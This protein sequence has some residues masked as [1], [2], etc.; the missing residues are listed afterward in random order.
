MQAHRSEAL[1]RSSRVPVAVPLLVTSL[2]PTNDF[3]EVCETLVVS[4]HGCALRSPMKVQAGIPVHFHTK[5]GR[6]MTAQIIDCEPIG[7]NAQAWRLGAQLEQPNNF[8][9]LNPCPEDW[10]RA[11]NPAKPAAK[12]AASGVSASLP[13]N[14]PIPSANVNPAFSPDQLG[15]MVSPLLLPLRQEITAI[16]EKLLQRESNRSRFEVSLSHIPPELEK[17]LWTRLRQDLGQRALEITREESERV[18]AAAHAAIEQKIAAAQ[19]E[20]QQ[21]AS[22]QLKGVEQRLHAL[23]EGLAENV[24]QH[25][26][27]AVQ[28]FQRTVGQAETRLVQES[29]RLA[30]A[31]HQRLQEEHRAQR[32]EMQQLQETVTAEWS[33]V[34][35]QLADV[36]DRLAKLDDSAKRLEADFDG[37]ISAMA[38]DTVAA[39]KAQFESAAAGVL[40]Q[41]NTR[42]A[43][44][45]GVQLEDACGR[46]KQVE[47]EIQVAMS[48]ALQSRAADSERYFEQA[49]NDLARQCIGDWRSAL[50]RQL[51]SFAAVLGEQLRAPSDSPS[52]E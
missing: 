11:Q 40:T 50:A 16:H 44:Q 24:Q 28:E 13:A 3:S 29:E 10:L 52:N 39:T 30:E 25:L 47:S 7:S 42:A 49:I 27:A 1:R 5:E 31:L 46:L 38:S 17:E 20:L 26:R 9:G 37:H 36:N 4:A 51:N 12:V 21:H 48:A 45:L 43:Q 32:Q 41:L 23:A 33:S 19:G 14:S 6:Q 35:R 18:L 34:L 8:W 15:K 2:D 22:V